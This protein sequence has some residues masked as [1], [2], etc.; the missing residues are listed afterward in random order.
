MLS[1]SK[2]KDNVT[3]Q[4]DLP[5]SNRV[6]RRKITWFDPYYNVNVET[7]IG[8]ASLKLID[9]HFSKTNKFHKIYNRNN[10]KIRYSSC[11]K[12]E[13]K[14]NLNIIVDIRILAL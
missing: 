10:V 1:A 4:T 14:D 11:L 3:Y 5:P 7:N 6:R 2:Y 12:R 13:P 8:K 9:K